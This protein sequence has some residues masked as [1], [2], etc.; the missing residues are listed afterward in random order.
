MLVSQVI[1]Y[2]K[3]FFHPP[4]RRY[5][6]QHSQY[7]VTTAI[8]KILDNKPGIFSENDMAGEFIGDGV[9][10]FELVGRKM[11]RPAMIIHIRDSPNGGS[12]ILIKPITAIGW[13]LMFFTA[14]TGTLA[15]LTH[16]IITNSISSLLNSL[17]LL[18]VIPI[19]CIFMARASDAATEDRFKRFIDKPIRSL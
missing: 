12:E 19:S 13:K 11:F 6:Y 17:V 7:E 3:E 4:E 9:F 16:F 15:G 10:Y 8:F 5:L 2:F 18:F 14:I 1:R